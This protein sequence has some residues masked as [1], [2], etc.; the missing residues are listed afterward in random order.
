V[1]QTNSLDAVNSAVINFFLAEGVD[2]RPNTGKNVFWNDRQGTLLVRATSQDLD[3]IEAAIHVLNIAPPQVTIKAKFVEVTQND[4]RALDFGILLG[5]TLAAGGRIGMQGGSALTFNGAPTTA[6]PLGTFP[7]SFTTGPDGT[8][9][10]TTIAP[11]AGDANLTGGIRNLLNAPPVFTLSGILTDPQFRV[12]INALEQRDG[13]DVLSEGQVTTLSGRQAQIQVVDIRQIVTGTTLGGFAGGG[14][15]G[16]GGG[17][18]ANV[19]TPGSQNIQPIPQPFPLGP[20]LDVIPYVDADGYTI[21]MTIIPTVV[22]FVGYDD[23]GPFSIQVQAL[24]GAGGASVP[25]TAVLPL[26]HF[27]LRQV[28]TSCI[29]WDGQTVVLGGLIS[30]NITRLKDK[31]PVLGD[32][33]LISRMFRSEKNGTEERN[34]LVFIT[35]TIVD[36][37]GNRVHPEET[38]STRRK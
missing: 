1:T 3:I 12:I 10:N 5:N 34:I 38:A 30:E 15:G 22:E 4:S 27:R 19:V 26:P 24:S 18:G 35:A 11:T 17:V 21:Q 6:N 7:G 33:P 20:T 13:A 23:P 16:V 25:L 2:L 8:T 28:T 31:V 9:V 32:V 37:A 14:G 36:P 29:V